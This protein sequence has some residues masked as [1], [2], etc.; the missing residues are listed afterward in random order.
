[1]AARFEIEVRADNGEFY[2]HLRSDN[3]RIIARS[4][5]TFKAKTT[6]IDEL[7]EIR[8]RAAEISVVDKTGAPST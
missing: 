2:W 3:N 5:E 6:C 1:M 7:T 4:A 8:E